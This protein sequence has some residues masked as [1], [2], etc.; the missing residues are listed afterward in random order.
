MTSKSRFKEYKSPHTA[1]LEQKDWRFVRA[2]S[3]GSYCH[4]HIDAS[5][6]MTLGE[7]QT[8][9]GNTLPINLVLPDLVTKGSNIIADCVP[10]VS[11]ERLLS[12]NREYSTRPHI[13]IRIGMRN[14]YNLLSAVLN[15]SL[16][17]V[18]SISAGT[19]LCVHDS[20]SPFLIPS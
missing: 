16:N 6:A 7:L 4:K 18:R 20:L 13:H 1:S 5:P 8:S 11:L 12:N 3:C 2:R 15:F 19:I 10:H 14:G 9:S 17:L